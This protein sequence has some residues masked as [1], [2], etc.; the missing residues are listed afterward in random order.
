MENTVNYPWE[1]APPGFQWAAIDENGW[2][3]WY[4]DEPKMANTQWA[5]SD[6]NYYDDEMRPLFISMGV[7]NAPAG[8]E[9]RKTLQKRP[10]GQ[11]K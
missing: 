11:N 2:A 10:E 9:W 8:F 5:A 1:F 3:Y 6:Y 4:R 7:Y